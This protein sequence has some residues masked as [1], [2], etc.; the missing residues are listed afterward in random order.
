MNNVKRMKFALKK[1][2]FSISEAKN[3]LLNNVKRMNFALRKVILNFSCE[4]KIHV[5][6]R[7]DKI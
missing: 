7:T 4:K 1:K 6:G 3:N 5:Q 2:L